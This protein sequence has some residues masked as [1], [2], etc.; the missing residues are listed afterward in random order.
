MTAGDL[1]TPWN[2]TDADAAATPCAVPLPVKTA[3]AVPPDGGLAAPVPVKTADAEPPAC[4]ETV[5]PPAPGDT[6]YA[7]PM[8]IEDEAA[9]ADLLNAEPA[10]WN[11]VSRSVT[12]VVDELCV[13]CPLT[14]SVIPEYA[15][16]PVLLQNP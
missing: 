7:H 4:P 10:E 15:V 2:V 11:V 12:D 8:P 1:A 14:V 9:V 16:V 3:E 5:A 6:T 13:I